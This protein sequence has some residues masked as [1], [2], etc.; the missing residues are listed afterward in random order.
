MRDVVFTAAVLAFACV[1]AIGANA[2]PLS[3]DAGAKACLSDSEADK[4][5]C[6]AYF[7]GRVER[8]QIWLLPSLTACRLE[9]IGQVDIDDFAAYLRQRGGGDSAFGS[10]VG[11]RRGMLPCESTLGFWTN[12]HLAELCR[13]DH[14][15]DSPCQHYLASLVRATLVETRVRG[16]QLFCPKGT[17]EGV[18]ARMFW[19]PV[20]ELLAAH[21]KWLAANPWKNLDSAA[22][23]F[24]DAMAMAYP[25]ADSE[26]RLHL[27]AF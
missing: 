13:A 18:E 7:R 23:G 5:R 2:L 10:Y 6:E 11:S 9:P 17:L 24:V 1:A 16:I 22:S 20:E 14:A 27:Q 12:D 8:Q 4:A 21:D 25:C 3:P 19:K 26:R 15:G